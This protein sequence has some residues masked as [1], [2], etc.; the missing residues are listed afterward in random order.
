MRNKLDRLKHKLRWLMIKHELSITL[1]FIVIS[2]ITI[3]TM[4]RP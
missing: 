3:V 4:L 2:T 1:L